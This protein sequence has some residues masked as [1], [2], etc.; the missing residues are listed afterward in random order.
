MDEFPNTCMKTTGNSQFTFKSLY[1]AGTVS[2]V[3]AIMDVCILR[4][5]VPAVLQLTDPRRRCSVSDVAQ[6]CVVISN[7]LSLF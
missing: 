2:G 7:N 5:Q 6:V 1:I 4:F 3:K